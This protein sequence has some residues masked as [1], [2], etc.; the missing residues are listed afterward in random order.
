MPQI[1]RE[2]GLDGLDCVISSLPFTVL[3]AQMTANIL[4]AVCRVLKPEGR[5]VAYQYSKIMKGCFE[6]R[7]GRV[8]T[9][10][11]LRNVPPAFVYDCT[12]P[13]LPE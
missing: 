4:D 12:Q 8:Q 9:S 2:H 3:P 10:F 5:F 1:L 6:G 13:R 11:V 7:F